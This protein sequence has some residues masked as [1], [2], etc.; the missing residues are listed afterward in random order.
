[1]I[2]KLASEVKVRD[3][4]VNIGLID[5]PIPKFS[6]DYGIGKTG[7][8]YLTKTPTKAARTANAEPRKIKPQ[9]PSFVRSSYF[10]S[11]LSIFPSILASTVLI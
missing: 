1:M 6:Q 8:K 2:L 9:K 10:A 7:N 3:V 11:T 4:N 5:F